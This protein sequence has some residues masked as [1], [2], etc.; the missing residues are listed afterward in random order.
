[1]LSR[2]VFLLLVFISQYSYSQSNYKGFIDKYPI[3]LILFTY[4]KQ[5]IRAIYS[6]QNF[7]EPIVIN[8]KFEKNSLILYEKNVQGKITATLIFEKYDS[9]SKLQKGIWKNLETNKQLNIS[10]SKEFDIE[11]GE[12]IEWNNLEILQPVS[13]KN[14]YFKLL[15]SKTKEDF[16]ARVTGIKILQ[17]KT[18]SLI[19]EIEMD[20]QFWGLSNVSVGDYNFDGIE[21]FSVFESS[22]AGPNTSSLYFL[23]DPETKKFFNSKFE[24]VSLDFDAKTKTIHE[25]NQCCAGTI[26]TT[27]VYKIV[28]NKMVLVEQHCLIWDEQKQDLVERPMKDCQ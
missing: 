13:L 18:D 9:K 17:K 19:Q 5:D 8:G 26:H 6:Y 27:A 21:D 14:Y 25:H 15:I 23:Y 24:G 1:M 10:L 11:N 28:N 7:D 3:E 16:E 20:C 2:I 22:Y 12:S 4:D